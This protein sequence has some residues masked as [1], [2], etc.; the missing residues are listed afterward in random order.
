VRRRLGPAAY[1]G[2][3][4]AG[5]TRTLEEAADDALRL[6]D[7]AT[8]EVAPQ[9]MVSGPGRERPQPRR[10]GRNLTRYG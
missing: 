10:P 1:A 7:R 2:A 6:L 8:T 4:A 5:T 9:G 3:W